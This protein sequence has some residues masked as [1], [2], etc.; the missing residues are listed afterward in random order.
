M[1]DAGHSRDPCMSR[2]LGTQFSLEEPGKTREG[3]AKDYAAFLQSGCNDFGLRLFEDGAEIL[4]TRRDGSN[5]SPLQFLRYFEEHPLPFHL[6]FDE[7]GDESEFLHPFDLDARSAFDG[8]V[9]ILADRPDPPDYLARRTK[10]GTEGECDLPRFFGRFDVRARRD[11]DERDP[12]PIQSIDDLALGLS[13]LPRGVLFEKDRRH[14]D[15]LSVRLEMS[16]QSDEGGPLETRRVRTVD[17]DLP[18]EV[19][20]ARTS[21]VEQDRDLKSDVEGLRI[22]RMGWFFVRLDQTGVRRSLVDEGEAS[23]RFLDG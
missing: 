8:Y 9:Q 4:E 23:L 22:W 11:F 10:E 19:D 6:L 13:Q 5:A 7:R 21:C 3:P 2:E 16:V 17:H 20:F 1:E 12:E 15:S 14:A 18:H